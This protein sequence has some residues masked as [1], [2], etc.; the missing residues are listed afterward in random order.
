MYANWLYLYQ[1]STYIRQYYILYTTWKLTYNLAKVGTIF[2]D[3]SAPMLERYTMQHIK[4]ACGCKRQNK[5]R[6][7]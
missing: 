3:C 7:K 4:K 6:I 5:K 1:P 2:C